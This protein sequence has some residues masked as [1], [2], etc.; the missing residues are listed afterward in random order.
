MLDLVKDAWNFVGGGGGAA[1]I[2]G[3]FLSLVAAAAGIIT[4]YAVSRRSVYINSITVERSKWI[5]KMRQAIAA[6]SAALGRRIYRVRRFREEHG[7]KKSLRSSAEASAALE[8]LNAAVSVIQLQLNPN[9]MIDRNILKLLDV[10]VVNDRVEFSLLQRADKLLISHSQWLLKKEWEKVKYEAG[11]IIYR[12]I[13]KKE[14]STRRAAYEQW[15]EGEGAIG[16]V[17]EEF[18]AIGEQKPSATTQTPPPEAKVSER[19]DPRFPTLSL[20]LGV[21]AIAGAAIY[22]RS[23]PRRLTPRPSARRR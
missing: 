1:L 13:H 8:E 9:G 12:R 18:R 11:G 21:G 6:Y 17:V 7:P 5:E 3:A 16:P 20:I 22:A 23:S 4:T 19:R 14:R 15:A 2:I 10:I